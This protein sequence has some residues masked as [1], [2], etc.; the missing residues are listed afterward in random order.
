MILVLVVLVRNTRTAVAETHKEMWASKK[1]AHL[2]ILNH[3]HMR[4]NN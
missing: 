4:Y 2:F 3:I 1:G